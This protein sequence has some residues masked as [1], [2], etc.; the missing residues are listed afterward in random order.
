MKLAFNNRGHYPDFTNGY[1]L[2][3]KRSKKGD[4]V[5]EKT[6]RKIIKSYCERLTKKLYDTG[7]ADLPLGLGSISAAILTRKPQYRGKTF[8]GYGKKDWST[9]LYDGKLKTFGLVYM[10]RHGKLNNLRCFGFV[11]NRQLFKRIK[12]IFLSEDCPWRPID[13]KEEMI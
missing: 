6:Y 2:Y 5:D 11:A 10:P 13:Y 12:N 9:G 3:V 4:F 7:M 1:S 8:I